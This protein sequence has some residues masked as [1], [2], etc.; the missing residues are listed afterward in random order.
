MSTIKEVLAKNCADHPVFYEDEA[1]IDLN[2]KI[3]ADWQRRDQ[4]KR[5]PTPGKNEKHYLAGV[6]HAGTGRVDYVS[7]TS[8]NSDLFIQMLN[9]LRRTYCCAKTPSR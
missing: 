2:P 9:H 1:D 7:S 3:G 5:T 4:Q 8:K 6:L